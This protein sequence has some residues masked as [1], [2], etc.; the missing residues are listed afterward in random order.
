MAPKEKNHH[1]KSAG[2][3]TEPVVP[4]RPKPQQE[5]GPGAGE[6]PTE[7]T[8]TTRVLLRW[9]WPSRVGM[10]ATMALMAK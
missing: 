2:Q 8:T 1:G 6:E 9:K 3:E 10:V 5:E 4:P 7:Q